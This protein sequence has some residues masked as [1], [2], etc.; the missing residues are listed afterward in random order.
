MKFKAT[1]LGAI[2]VSAPIIACGNDG[3]RGAYVICV[4]SL[5]GNQARDMALRLGPA[6]S[7]RV[8]VDWL[9][10]ADRADRVYASEL[11]R[12][13][14]SIFS[15]DTSGRELEIFST[16]IDEAKDSLPPASQAKVFTVAATPSRLGYMLRDDDAA[17]ILVPLIEKEYAADSI[18][19]AQFRNSYNK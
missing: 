5:P 18:A 1:L 4:D 13:L 15:C 16:A 2:L 17:A 8:L 14:S 10:T 3:V 19:L 11:A 9:V 12:E 6:E 7:A